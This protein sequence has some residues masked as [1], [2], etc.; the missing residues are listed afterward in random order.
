[1]GWRRRPGVLPRPPGRQTARAGGRRRPECPRAPPA[2]RRERYPVSPAA[3]NAT[4]M[5]PRTRSGLGP[6]R[7]RDVDPGSASRSPVGR[8]DRQGC[9]RWLPLLVGLSVESP[10]EGSAA[11]SEPPRSAPRSAREMTSLGVGV[12]EEVVRDRVD[13]VLV[14]MERVETVDPPVVQSASTLSPQAVWPPRW[15]VGSGQATNA[16]ASTASSAAI[17]SRWRWVRGE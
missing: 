15:R 12:V 1:M 10:G 8:L 17:A 7:G 2:R 3:H 16:L 13:R 11:W 5:P 4:D 14:A 6:T 9:L